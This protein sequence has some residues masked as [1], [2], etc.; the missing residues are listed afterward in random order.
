[1]DTKVLYINKK[2]VSNLMLKWIKDN[3]AVLKQQ[4]QMTSKL[5]KRYS[6]LVN[7]LVFKDMQTKSDNTFDYQFAT[8]KKT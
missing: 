8:V 1:M 7:L 3:Q 5:L 2:K 6:L 4:I